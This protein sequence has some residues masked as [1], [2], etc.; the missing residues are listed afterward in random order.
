LYRR[1]T[2]I[3][4]A[5]YRTSFGIDSRVV[6]RERSMNR[7]SQPLVDGQLEQTLAQAADGAV[8]I[9][10][11]GRIVLWND[12]AERIMGYAPGEA[13]G[14][15]CCDLF[16]GVGAD[17]NRV[18]HP[19]CHELLVTMGES[20]RTV[21]M[22]VRTKSGRPVWINVSILVLPENRDGVPLTIH[23]FRDI[24]ASKELLARVQERMAPPLDPVEVS[25]GVLTTRELELLGLMTLGLEIQEAAERLQVSPARVR[26]DVQSIFGKLGVHSRVEAVAYAHKHHLL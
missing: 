11:N 9:G 19:G 10:P 13:I 24:T 7:D 18:C 8:V 2:G 26:N 20:A 16:A 5:A 22:L 23:L 4:V 17:G 25:P 14:G 12:A 21:D 1:K 3:P 15:L 6:S